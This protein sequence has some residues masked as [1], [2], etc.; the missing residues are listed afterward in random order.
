[1][2]AKCAEVYDGERVKWNGRVCSEERN[3]RNESPEC[4]AA[5]ETACTASTKHEIVSFSLAPL[6]GG[7]GNCRLLVGLRPLNKF[8][9]HRFVR[10]RP[11]L[12]FNIILLCNRVLRLR[13]NAYII[14]VMLK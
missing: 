9:P 5:I 11:H 6:K 13:L 12:L 8:A 10:L 3:E 7:R 4:N 1:M 14:C 2:L